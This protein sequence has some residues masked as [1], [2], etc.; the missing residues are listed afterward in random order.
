MKADD[1]IETT[2]EIC[3]HEHCLL[4]EWNHWAV[5]NGSQPMI[6]VLPILLSLMHETRICPQGHEVSD[7]GV[8]P[9]MAL[10]V[11]IQ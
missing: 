6:A 5:R 2:D 10:T 7:M 8:L 1:K 11:E 9:W 3:N 4:Q